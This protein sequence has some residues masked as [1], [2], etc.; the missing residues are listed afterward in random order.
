MHQI[1]FY[2]VSAMLLVSGILTVTSTR[3]FRAAVYL[4]ATLLFTAGIYFMMAFN[5]IAIVQIVIYVGGIVVLILFSILLTHT[6]GATVLKPGWKA[7]LSG[8][9]VSGAGFALTTYVFSGYLFK[10]NTSAPENMQVKAIG[11]QLLNATQSGYLLPFELITV[12]LLVAMISSITIAVGEDKLKVKKPVRDNLAE[13]L[14][15]ILM[16]INTIKNFDEP[17]S[18]EIG[19]ESALKK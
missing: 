16:E 3:F 12:L 18:E 7:I 19:G 13:A 1:L 11:N 6:P 9:L 2:T 5:F 17:T 15:K 8:L 14:N 10:A 4:L